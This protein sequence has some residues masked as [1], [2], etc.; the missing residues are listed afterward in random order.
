MF[1]YILGGTE[2]EFDVRLRATERLKKAFGKD[3]TKLLD[4]LDTFTIEDMIK[5]IYNVL[6]NPSMDYKEF[7]DWCYDNLGKGDLDDC[8]SWLVQQLQY[9]GISEEDFL[10]KIRERVAQEKSITAQD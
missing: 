8:A 6:N 4:Q 1:N 7:K 5:F 2:F 9:P 3:Y 10:K